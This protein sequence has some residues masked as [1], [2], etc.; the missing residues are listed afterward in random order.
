MTGVKDSAPG[1]ITVST[2]LMLLT[3]TT[4]F[5]ATARSCGTVT[6]AFLGT[7]L[8]TATAIDMEKLGA[9][10]DE[11]WDTDE[12]EWEQKIREVNASLIYNIARLEE[13][14]DRVAALN[15]TLFLWTKNLNK[16]LHLDLT[17]MQD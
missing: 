6:M 7:M 1:G 17:L 16:T 10:R 13:T 2:T 4:T 8:P 15:K 3:T 5:H 14:E 12:E 9:R 11:K